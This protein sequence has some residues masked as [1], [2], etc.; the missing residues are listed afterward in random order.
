M[1][2][3]L[4]IILLRLKKEKSSVCVTKSENLASASQ[5]LIF[6][7]LELEITLVKF[8]IVLIDCAK[9]H[10]LHIFFMR[11]TRHLICEIHHL[12]RGI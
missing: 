12:T 6:I 7:F 8:F 3:C 5:K 9:Y 4:Q 10:N 2:A 1:Y 11:E